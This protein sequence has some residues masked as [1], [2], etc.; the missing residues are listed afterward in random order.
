MHGPFVFV[1]TV[2]HLQE[3]CVLIFVVIIFQFFKACYSVKKHTCVNKYANPSKLIQKNFL[4]LRNVF[5]N[6]ENIRIFFSKQKNK[7]TEKNFLVPSAR[8]FDLK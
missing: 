8:K 4:D 6:Q 5:S 2:N 7:L 3:N 1:I